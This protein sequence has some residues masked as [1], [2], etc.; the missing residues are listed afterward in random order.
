MRI[1]RFS[2][3]HLGAGRSSG[4]LVAMLGVAA[5]LACSST[6]PPSDEAT[7]SAGTNASAS[8]TATTTPDAAALNASAADGSSLD[9]LASSDAS[10]N[11]PAVAGRGDPLSDSLLISAADRGRLVGRDSGTI[12]VV[13]ISD[14]QCPYCKQWHDESMAAVRKN[15]V[16]TGR[17]R[18]A[19]LHFPLEQH[20]H[21]RAEAE[22][23]L[24]A[25]VQGRFYPYSDELFARQKEIGKVGI[26]QPIL[27]DVARKLA[28]DMPAF[29][30]CQKREAI[31]AVVESDVQQASKA[32]V[33]STPTFLVGD[34]LLEGAVPYTDFR[35]AIDSALVMANKRK[36]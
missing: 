31:R 13:M 15:Y 18:F 9:A 27:A 4:T 29:A 33:R 8:A 7:T 17:V 30:A 10:A 19:Y 26:V 2:A 6:R 24:C 11:V 34:F 3:L 25:G 20:I 16:E 36:R 28:L 5:S 1:L 32:G 14:Y 35:R 12:W 22:A 21:A 23:A